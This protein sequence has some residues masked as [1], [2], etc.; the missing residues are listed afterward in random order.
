MHCGLDL[1]THQ[2]VEFTVNLLSFQRGISSLVAKNGGFNTLKRVFLGITVGKA[3]CRGSKRRLEIQLDI[4]TVGVQPKCSKHKLTRPECKRVPWRVH[5]GDSNLSVASDRSSSLFLY[6]KLHPDP[7]EF[8]ASTRCVSVACCS[9][10]WLRGLALRYTL[11][12]Q[13]NRMGN[14]CGRPQEAEDV[15][16]PSVDPPQVEDDQTKL[17]RWK[18]TGRIMLPASAPETSKVHPA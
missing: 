18:A 13:C 2:V 11:P 7:S 16:E 15:Q 12:L 10:G 9:P 17:A 4:I 1:E 3:S 8:A 14:C 6:K 5:L